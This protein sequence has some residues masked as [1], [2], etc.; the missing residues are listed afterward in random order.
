MRGR[1][2]SQLQT[3][4]GE[5]HQ[6][7]IATNS[8]SGCSSL[9]LRVKSLLNKTNNWQKLKGN[10]SK[11]LIL[12]MKPNWGERN[13]QPGGGGIRQTGEVWAAGESEPVGPV[14]AM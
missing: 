12:K 5:K 2:G 7:S 11:N 1:G 3:W 10:V 14:L 13:G 6:G 8:G 9:S 4:F